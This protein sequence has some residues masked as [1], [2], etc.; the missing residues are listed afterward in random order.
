MPFSKL[1]RMILL[2]MALASGGL[3]IF[4]MLNPPPQ[5]V[6]APPPV[7]LP[8][9]E[10]I[11]VAASDLPVGYVLDDAS[12]AWQPLASGPAPPGLILRSAGEAAL[13]DLRGAYVR[14]M[15]AAGEP[16]RRERLVRQGRASAYLAAN[17]APDMRAIAIS[18]D[19]NGLATAGGFVQPGDRVDIIRLAAGDELAD[20]P[21]AQVIMRN[22]RVLAIGA[23][24]ERN[25]ERPVNASTATLE[26]SV[27]QAHRL[28]AIQ[29]GT[30]LRLLL[31]STADF[32]APSEMLA[33]RPEGL[34]NIVRF[35][36]LSGAK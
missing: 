25:L 21:A 22:V 29:R 36:I 23:V 7:A 6:V 3:A 26:V 33:E 20:Q 15:I 1:L 17:L 32:D 11:L 31:R 16:I 4:F 19:P 34:T 12:F 14:Q 8:R 30:N 5:Q 35:G 2:V 18:I 10:E 9:A 28:L 13:K 24:A 27:A